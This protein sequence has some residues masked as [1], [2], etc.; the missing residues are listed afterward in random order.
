MGRDDDDRPSWTEREKKSFS[1]LDRQRR[2]G[3]SSGERRP[4]DR[5]A[6]ARAGAAAKQYMKGLDGLF[7]KGKGG[8]KGDKL[9]AAVRDARGTPG[10]VEAC[11]AYRDEVGAP[12]D[13]GLIG[14][15]LD[16]GEPEFEICGLE[17]LR[18]G[19]DAGSVKATPG[20]RTQLRLL[21]Q[22]GDDAV[23][24]L[25]EELLDRS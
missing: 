10:L 21:A 18:S 20:L 1:E 8:A 11:R 17:A 14:C 25:A 22:S 13:A 19:Y 9:A 24:E 12:P 2:E 15:F 16:S 3:R 23:A 7:A 4:R 5:A 6:E